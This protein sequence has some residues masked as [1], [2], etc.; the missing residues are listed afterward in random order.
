MKNSTDELIYAAQK[1][2]S[3]ILAK[4]EI[5]TGMLVETIVVHD[6]DITSFNDKLPQIH[7][8]VLIE[9]KRMPGQHW[10]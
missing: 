4:L 6:I 5:D 7:R 3:N 2:I 8:S 9:M 10:D 1:D